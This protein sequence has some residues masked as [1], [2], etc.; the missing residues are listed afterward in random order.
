M[1]EIFLFVFV[2]Q[3]ILDGILDILNI[4]CEVLGSV[5]VLQRTLIFVLF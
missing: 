4:F 1:G 3:E 5:N 2:D